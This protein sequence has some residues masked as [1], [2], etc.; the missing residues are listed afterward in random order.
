MKKLSALL[1]LPLVLLG[2]EYEFLTPQVLVLKSSKPYKYTSH[3]VKKSGFWER[4]NALLRDKNDKILKQPDI[5]VF[6]YIIFEKPLKDGE[7][8]T[9]LGAVCQYF[10]DK[11]SSIFKLNQVGNGIDQKKKFAYM[12]AWLGSAGALPLKHLAGEAFE[13]RN[14]RDGKTVFAGKLQLRPEDVRYRGKI[15][16]TG[17]EV[18]ELDYSDFNTPGKY[19]FFVKGIGRSM[20]F[21][22]GSDT[23]N[24]AFYI[25]A[26]GLYHK[27]C[28][29]AK[30][31]PF[32]AWHSPVCHQHRFQGRF[33]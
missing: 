27:R 15:P 2:G 30:T 13:I 33:L 12:G 29:I 31:A 11:P 25:H 3:T 4:E 19:Y 10:S 14:S 17:E 5:T 20:D 7:K 26:R 8:V 24:E 28:G 6:E 23:I 9:I 32:T 21:I 16:F 18:L 22:I 1:L